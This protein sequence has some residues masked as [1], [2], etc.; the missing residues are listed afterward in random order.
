M[1]YVL[2]SVLFDA[3]HSKRTCRGLLQMQIAAN[4]KVA[5]G[6]VMGRGI[7]GCTSMRAANLV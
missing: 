2:M 3:T 4:C 7:Y 6:M 1:I 5:Q